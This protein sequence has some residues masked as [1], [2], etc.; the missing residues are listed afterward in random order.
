SF[1]MST[2]FDRKWIKLPRR[3]R[4]EATTISAAVT[5]EKMAAPAERSMTASRSPLLV[6]K[7][8]SALNDMVPL[9][10]DAPP[11]RAGQLVRADPGPLTLADDGAR[12]RS[13]RALP[14]L[15]RVVK[16]PHLFHLKGHGGP[17]PPGGSLT[18]PLGHHG[19]EGLQLLPFRMALGHPEVDP[20]PFPLGAGRARLEDRKDG[21]G[22]LLEV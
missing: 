10:S 15:A 13:D 22:I 3:R 6:R 18:D 9:F 16:R 7:P 19:P 11:C 12:L 5:A 1:L 14:P 8:W 2:P 20:H 4:T 21:V 17:E